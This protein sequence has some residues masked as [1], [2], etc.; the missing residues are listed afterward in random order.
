MAAGDVVISADFVVSRTTSRAGKRRVIVGTVTLDG[1]NPTPVALAGYVSALDGGVVSIN[2][3][4]A[5]GADPT[6]VTCLV[7][8]TTLDVYAWKATTAGAG[9]NA[10]MIASTNNTR[11]IDFIAI[12]PS[13]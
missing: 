2:G 10:D 3:S 7:N 8:G 9:G 6:A 4:G 13:K 5:P 1:S 12:G 11:L